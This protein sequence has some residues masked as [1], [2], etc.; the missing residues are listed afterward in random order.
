[1]LVAYWRL[2]GLIWRQPDINE[3]NGMYLTFSRQEDRAAFSVSPSEKTCLSCHCK[4][5]TLRLKFFD[6]NLDLPKPKCIFGVGRDGDGITSLTKRIT[7]EEPT[8]SCSIE[9]AGAVNLIEKKRTTGPLTHRNCLSAR[10][11]AYSSLFTSERKMRA[12][13]L[14]YEGGAKNLEDTKASL[15]VRQYFMVHG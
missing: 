15:L 12:F 7:G 3:Q 9:F 1:M 6:L 10:T 2:P 8:K 4:S 11:P 13:L 14:V 5:L